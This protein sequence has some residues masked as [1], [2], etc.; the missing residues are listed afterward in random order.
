MQKIYFAVRPSGYSNVVPR[1]DWC[2]RAASPSPRFWHAAAYHPLRRVVVLVGGWETGQRTW[3][4]DGVDWRSFPAS[5]TAIRAKHAM[6]YDSAR[7]V[8][9]LVGGQAAFPEYLLSSEVLE[10]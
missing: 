8:M 9:V 10:Y 3:E 6:A 2:A 4:W 7:G 5:P 1:A